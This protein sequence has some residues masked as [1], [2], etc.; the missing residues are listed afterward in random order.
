MMTS[1]AKKLCRKGW[2]IFETID[3]QIYLPIQGELRSIAIEGKI[4]VIDQIYIDDQYRKTDQ[5]IK[6]FK[7]DC[8]KYEAE[9]YFRI[10]SNT[11]KGY[12]EDNFIFGSAVEQTESI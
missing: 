10:Q 1:F 5:M 12:L 4:E 9:K 3:P 11:F 6:E 7:D 2:I 8:D